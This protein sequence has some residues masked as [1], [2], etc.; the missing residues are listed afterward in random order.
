MRREYM[1][2]GKKLTMS[3]KLGSNL[4]QCTL[5]QESIDFPFSAFHLTTQIRASV[6]PE[7]IGIDK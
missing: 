7:M 2:T 1:H 3:G 6:E 4:F 5:Q